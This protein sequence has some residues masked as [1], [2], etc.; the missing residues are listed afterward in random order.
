LHAA[1]VLE[2]LEHVAQDE[3]AVRE[4]ARVL[5]PGGTLVLSVPVPPGETDEGQPW[6]HKREGY[7]LDQ[8]MGLLERN[9]FAV[10]AH[11]FAEF[12]FSRLKRFEPSIT[13]GRAQKRR[14]RTARRRRTR[15]RSD[16]S[17]TDCAT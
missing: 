12:K 17:P 3:Q 5:A 15:S 6:G 13:S 9:G 11:R 2:T 16:R 4:F 14:T 7:T 1:L 10:A 8:I